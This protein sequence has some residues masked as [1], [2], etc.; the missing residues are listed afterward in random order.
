MTGRSGVRP[1]PGAAS[2][3]RSRPGHGCGACWGPAGEAGAGEAPEVRGRRLRAQAGAPCQRRLRRG[4]GRPGWLPASGKR[5]A[6]AQSRA[7]GARAGGEGARPSRA[8]SAPPAPRA[9]PSGAAGSGPGAVPGADGSSA[10]GR[11]S[12]PPA[13]LGA[14]P[15]P[16]RAPRGPVALSL[17]SWRSPSPQRWDLESGR[18]CCLPTVQPWGKSLVRKSLVLIFKMGLRAVPIRLV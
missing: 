11:G 3:G 14:T 5:A 12:R 4:S 6:P 17:L 13:G 16:P 1:R 18:S 8:G 10:Q 15:L 7:R 9:P 2:S